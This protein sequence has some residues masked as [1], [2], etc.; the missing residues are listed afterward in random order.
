MVPR[1]TEMREA[2]DAYE[3]LGGE[4]LYLDI[5][6]ELAIE[7]LRGH[8]VDELLW[9]VARNTIAKLGFE[10]CVIYL[11][12]EARQVLVQR[13]AFG[14]KSPEGATIVNPIE[15]AV[16]EGIVGTAA[17]TKEPVLVVDVREDAR[18]IVDD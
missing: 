18:Y 10:D 6:R 13:A 1:P 8:G 15:I 4:A 16:G 11:L 3:A 5:I 14:P 7:I 17:R 9:L 12:D 2:T